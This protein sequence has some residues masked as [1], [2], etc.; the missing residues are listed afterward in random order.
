MFKSCHYCQHRKKKCVRP[1]QSSAISDNRCLACQHLDL[2]CEIGIRKASIKRQ[3]KSQQ[4]ASKLYSRLTAESDPLSTRRGARSD[5]AVQRVNN[6]DCQ[7]LGPETVASPTKIIITDYNAEVLDRLDPSEKYQRI[8][9][10]EFPFVPDDLLRDDAALTS[11][12]LSY[13]IDLAASLSLQ[14]TCSGLSEV[15]M[16]NLTAFLEKQHLDTAEATGLTLLLPRIQ[17]D[18]RLADKVSIIVRSK[19]ELMLEYRLFALF[20]RVAILQTYLCPLLLPH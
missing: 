17:L 12:A 19:P 4:I 2:H 6:G 14:K 8:V 7:L 13:C 16:Q 10:L 9:R 11:P 5:T 1:A 20:V 15:A 3:R 18:P